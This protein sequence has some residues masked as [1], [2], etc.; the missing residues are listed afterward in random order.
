M[1]AGPRSMIF[2]NP[3]QVLTCMASNAA[4]RQKRKNDRP[5]RTAVSAFSLDGATSPYPFDRDCVSGC[6]PKSA[7][8]AN[9]HPLKNSECLM[10]ESIKNAVRMLSLPACFSRSSQVTFLDKCKNRPLRKKEKCMEKCESQL[11]FL[12]IC[13]ILLLRL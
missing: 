12:R 5:A 7:L 6:A 11:I 3:A 2:Q 9:R 8:H 10:C 1:H 4:C 13:A